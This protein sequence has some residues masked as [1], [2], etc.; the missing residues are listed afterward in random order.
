[1][2]YEELEKQIQELKDNREQLSELEEHLNDEINWRRLLVNESR[3]GIVILR[4]DGSVFEANRKYADMLGYTVEEV[5]QLHVWDWDTEATKEEILAMISDVDN[6]S[7]HHFE[8]RH[9]RKDGSIIDVE[10]CNSGS[11][12][13]G[14]K[15]IFC[16]SRDITERK[17]NA[18]EREKLICELKEALAENKSLRGIIPVCA[19]C[20][21][22]RDDEGYWEQVDVYLHKKSKVDITHSICPECFKKYYPEGQQEKTDVSN[23]DSNNDCEKQI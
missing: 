20:K 11:E 17:K 18:A 7:G 8:T 6:I 19:Y 12:Y 4:R 5:S 10:L 21:K 23:Q 2:T 9:C 13:R 15:L 3:D 1:M 14:Q 16:I 22:V